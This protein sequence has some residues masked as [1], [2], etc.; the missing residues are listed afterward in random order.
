MIENLFSS[1]NENFEVVLENEMP[2]VSI[3]DSRTVIKQV[4]LREAKG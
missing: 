2:G 4:E 3:V 1:K